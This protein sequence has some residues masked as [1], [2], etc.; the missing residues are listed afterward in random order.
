MNISAALRHQARTPRFALIVLVLTAAVV[1][2]NA[3]AFGAIHALRWKA[4]PYA[5]AEQLI[6]LRAQ[7]KNFGM[8]L[9]LSAPLREAVLA[10]R[11]HFSGALGFVETSENESGRAWHVYRV[12]SDFNSFLGVTPELGRG[13]V[14]SD[15]QAGAD[16]VLVLSDATWRSRYGADPSI[17]GRAVRFG[18]KT[19]T[20]IGVMP[21]GF[22]FPDTAT[23]AWRPFVESPAEREQASSGVVGVL[24]VV[25]RRAPGISID[26]TRKALE[27]ILAHDPTLAGLRTSAGVIAQVR[28][29]RE[30]FT[31]QH[32]Q[33]LAL[34]QLAALILLTVVLSNLVNIELDRL[35]ARRRELDVRRALGA[36]DRTLRRGLVAEL[37]PP[38]VAGL[39]LGLAA[40]PFALDIAVETDLLPG[41]TPQGTGFAWPSLAAGLV[42]ALVL[43]VVPV[44]ALST[45]R[46]GQLNR[47]GIGGLGR[48]RSV[49]LV[50][51]ITLT[52]ALLG[53]TA[54]L[55]Q[56][57]IR[58]VSVDPGFDPHGVILTEVD[59]AGVTVGER[60]VDRLDT[61]R[62]RPLVEPIRSD[63]DA[64][65]GID[66]VAVVSAPP[67]SN[68]ESVSTMRLPGQ[69]DD[70]QVHRREIGS[71]YFGAMGI[72]LE[73][74]RDFVAGGDAG[75]VIVDD[76]YTERYL[77][78]LDPLT[79]YVELPNG[80]GE[81]FK[82]IPII[83]VVHTVKS[84]VLDETPDLAT[85]YSFDP[86][87]MP[88]FWLVTR[89]HG[90]A[91]A[92][93]DVIR[94]R[95]LERAPDATIVL[96]WALSDR[97]AETL[98]NRESLLGA[99][100]AFAAA[101][102]ALSMISLAAVLS[103]AIRRRT[104]EI[105]IRIALGATP[106]R[107]RNLVLRQGT[108]LVGTG[109][110]LGLAAGLALARVL[111]DRLFG[112]EFTDPAS[113]LAT[114]VLVALV[115]LVACWWPARRASAIDPVEALRSD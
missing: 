114:L 55:L 8:T 87:P 104:A 56:S 70:L 18:S 50:A 4:M 74:G 62:Y 88:T 66:R 30:R 72:R 15:A 71:G 10:D 33:A 51:Q 93:A 16:A 100:G 82:R 57:A 13:F 23:D 52:T 49:L 24:E 80:D 105:G 47:A 58:I 34:F 54:L 43:L 99:L 12:T 39:L 95:I 45:A 90:D 96:N 92:L 94:R 31:G 6:D 86:A 32:E 108:L 41:Y 20:I 19:Y 113:W 106:A 115:A 69:T 35:I 7:L 11:S 48:L 98:K 67:F 46:V 36:T 81:T 85:I 76:T 26:E 2:V 1:A 40:T 103:S 22:A 75:A 9:G 68:S 53:T 59:L 27:L 89:T 63:I 29:W 42:V 84:H 79:Q 21:R 64:L 44:V 101:T 14:N 91:H 77:H 109:I 25:A 112:I 17:V 107:V 61:D 110:A 3:T 28:P 37:L 5:D 111:A 73:A 83:G 38:V 102:L 97:I 65:P 60:A 78:G